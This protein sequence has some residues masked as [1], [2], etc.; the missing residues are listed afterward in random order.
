MVRSLALLAAVA[1]AA[2]AADSTTTVSLLLPMFDPQP[3]VA[4]VVKAD[5]T[6]TAFAIACAPDTPAEKCGVPGTQVIWQ[7]PSTW[8]L[9]LSQV[10]ADEGTL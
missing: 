9:T 7:G 1:G 3:L 10:D 2:S 4:S 6:I 8:S 5:A